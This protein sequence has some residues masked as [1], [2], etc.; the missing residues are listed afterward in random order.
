[1]KWRKKSKHKEPPIPAAG[2]DAGTD[3]APEND[4]AALLNAKGKKKKPAK[5]ALLIAGGAC[6]LVA[7]AILAILL[8]PKSDEASGE[9]VYREYTVAYG[10]I[11]VGQTES[12]SISLTRETVTFPVSATVEE[13]YVKAGS[14]VQEGDP[15]MK[16]SVEDVEYSLASYDLQLEITGLELEQAKLQ[17]TT[18]LLQAKQQLETSR[19][20]GS[21]AGDNYDI[22]I[23]ELQLALDK[24][25]D[26]LASAQEELSDYSN[27]SATYDEDYTTLT[28][29]EYSVDY[30]ED[31]VE[32]LQDQIGNVTDY[33]SLL[34]AAK[35]SLSSAYSSLQASAATLDANAVFSSNVTTENGVSSAT[36]LANYMKAYYSMDSTSAGTLDTGVSINYSAAYSIL[37]TWQAIPAI[38]GDSLAASALSTMISALNQMDGYAGN[39]RHYSAGNTSAGNTTSALQ[40]QLESAQSS[41]KTAQEK[42][43][44][45][46]S[47]FTETYGSISDAEELADKIKTAEQDVTQ[48]EISLLKAQ[49]SAQT[50]E[51]KADQTEESARNESSTAAATYELTEMELSQAVDAAQ[52]EYD[53]LET[54]IEEARTL[55]AN[56]GIVYAPCNGM[57]SAVNVAAGDS[58]SVT[59]DQESKR[60]GNYAQL[61]AMTNISD[62][63]VPITISE[64]DILDVY[65]GQEASVTMT[66]F[67]GRTFTAEVDT[68]SVESSRSGAATVSYNVNILFSDANSLDMFE[69]MSAEVTLIQRAAADVLYINNQAITYADGVAT[70]LKR[71]DDGAG[72]VTV[73]TTGFSDG[74]YVEILSGLNEGDVVL[75]ES[76]V[77]RS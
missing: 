54:Q 43:E 27:M 68:I 57:V 52:E 2:A 29:L 37:T 67:P 13:V 32:E 34:S 77:G 72:V 64:E 73:V 59:F 10:D 44:S 28:N 71:G 3:A 50:G 75:V 41:L 21:L 31:L 38:A 42:Y 16:L 53:S 65:I 35:S 56:D 70:V 36:E 17:L 14:S 66:S 1:M 45:F 30:Y 24:A 18:K 47:D 15:L 58:I 76:A 4:L 20:T 61:L 40:S 33:A 63:Y 12:S 60:I 9:T 22:T 7:G 11:T 46:K 25:N 19:E 8:I 5:K 26:T 48:A 51:T 49:L 62:V 74:Q 39:V 69:G 23:A 6:V 55:I